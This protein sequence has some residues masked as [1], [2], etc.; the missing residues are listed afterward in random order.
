MNQIVFD[1]LKIRD[2]SVHY[3]EMN[4]WDFV[5]DW[6]DDDELDLSLI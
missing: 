3:P 1:G 4:I 2:T 6:E 5:D